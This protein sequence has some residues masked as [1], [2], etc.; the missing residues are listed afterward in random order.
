MP[1][2]AETR[3]PGEAVVCPAGLLRDSGRTPGEAS[4][5]G[6]GG[7]H[8]PMCWQN[9]KCPLSR[10]QEQLEPVCLTAGCPLPTPGPTQA[11]Q[12][13]APHRFQET[14]KE[15]NQARARGSPQAHHTS[16]TQ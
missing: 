14:R 13:L 4:Q 11:S 6:D 10:L 16:G 12:G 7:T 8:L 5:Q 3:E 15:T 1:S 2:S 9:L